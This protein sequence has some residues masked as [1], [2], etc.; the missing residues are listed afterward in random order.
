MRKFIKF[1]VLLLCSL[2]A[3]CVSCSS[4][5]GPSDDKEVPPTP[6]VNP[7]EL[8]PWEENR[9]ALLN[10][11][12][13]VLIYGGGHH[14]EPYNWDVDRISSYVTYKDKA[15]TEH[16]L[17]DAFLFLE[18]K[19]TG[20]GG[21]N[22]T[23]TY[24]NQEGLDAAN[25]KDW[26]RLVDYY[27]A[28]STGLGALNRAISNAQ[29][30]LGTPKTKHRV[31]IAIPE[32]VTHK[33]PANENSTT[34]YWGSLDGHIM[35]FSIAQD[36]VDACKWYINYVRS[37]FNE[38]QYQNIELAGFYWLAET[39]GTTRDI[40]SKVGVYVNQ[41]KYSFNW[42][43][44]R[45]A[46][47]HDRWETL[48]FNNAYYQPNYFFNTEQSYAVL[49]ETCKTAKREQYLLSPYERLYESI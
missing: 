2:M 30:R 49:E 14:R 6:P 47:G 24:E 46:E 33:T 36:R 29:K 17:F 32:P 13:M 31:V 44:Y 23:Y 11:T 10:S 34:V 18:L 1:S 39:A 19:D 41:F 20:N 15:G 25:Q 35:D 16:W 9:T 38:M 40:I 4:S 7:G 48:G 3:L 21:T 26:K 5:D 42:I 28:S 12:D 27:F 37:K 8:Y 43:P 45:G 22:K